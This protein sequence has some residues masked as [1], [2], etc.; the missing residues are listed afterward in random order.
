MLM[1]ETVVLP[2]SPRPPQP[3]IHA[4][5]EV[6]R[7][8]VLV[9]HRRMGKTVC[10]INHLIKQ[11]LLC[12]KAGGFYGYVAPYRNQAK[13]IAW[14]YLKH[15]TRPIPGRAVNENELSISLPG[16]A[17]VR[18]FGADNPDN[19][20]GLYFDGVVLDE[21]AQMKPEVW[22]EI[23]RPA[24]SDR[25]GFAVFI[26]TPKGVNLFSELYYRAIGGAEGWFG[27][28]YTADD[29]RVLSRAELEAARS[30]MG[31]AAYRREYLCDFNAAVEDILI[32]LA[33]VEAA[34]RREHHPSALE[35]SPKVLGVDVA[36]FGDD[37]SALILRRGLAAN[38]PVVL[39]GL[40][41]ME[42]AD[43]VAWEM[44][45]H[46]PEGVFID[47]GRGEGVID[48]LRQ[49]GF[50][51]TAINFGSKAA[52]ADKYVNKRSEMWARLAQWIK[53][54]GA[55]PDHL[56]L[57]SELAAPTYYF[58][59][60]GRLGLESKDKIKERLGKSPDIADALALTF[61]SFLPA[62]LTGRMALFPP[63]L[64]HADLKSYNPVKV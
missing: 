51:V 45:R 60:S 5:L 33:E 64:A 55:I 37:A 11:A 58:D 29:T 41:N 10:V 57:K 43:R 54:G 31:E 9:A 42:V 22:H 13:T 61:A 18:L 6:N 46:K 63:A 4:A 39:R 26:G 56:A 36:R 1:S 40:D 38:A 30:E 3:E 48:R 59:S 20:R 53:E 21:V 2:Y 25:Q 47:E 62:R 17:K 44:G 12:P 34:A 27:G 15:F 52:E 16:G 32:S 24:L 50:K 7:F 23:I 49:L 19:L 28:M 14:D 8:C 35:F